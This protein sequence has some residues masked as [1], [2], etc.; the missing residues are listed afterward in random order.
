MLSRNINTDLIM[1][2]G[3]CSR[4]PR[5]RVADV[6]PEEIDVVDFMRLDR[7]PILDRIW[8]VVCHEVFLPEDSLRIFAI[9]NAERMHLRN[10][11]RLPEVSSLISVA[12][13][14]LGNKATKSDVESAYCAADEASVRAVCQASSVYQASSIA[15]YLA[16]YGGAGDASV[17]TALHAV[18]GA[19]SGAAYR[20]ACKAIYGAV[21]YKAER[22]WQKDR[23]VKILTSQRG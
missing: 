20:S 7:I 3:P 12:R 18:F 23:L 9:D 16:A 1:S 19:A 14:Y 6:L 22:D 21:D 15:V 2:L 5:S 8:C 11:K 13:R 10:D 4:W 17:S